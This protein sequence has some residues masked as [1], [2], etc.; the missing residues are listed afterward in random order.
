MDFNG[1]NIKGKDVWVENYVI[2]LV[3]IL[4]YV[5]SIQTK[6]ESLTKEQFLL[7]LEGIR[8]E[9]HEDLIDIYIELK[10]LRKNNPDKFEKYFQINR[11]SE[12]PVKKFSDFQFYYL[13]GKGLKKDMFSLIW[14]KVW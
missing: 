12:D 4:G 7:G 8:E 3:D 1:N 6:C 13:V 11:F 10:R 9:V 2:P 14:L 5:E